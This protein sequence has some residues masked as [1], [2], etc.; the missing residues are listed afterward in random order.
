[1]KLIVFDMDGVLVDSS[2]SHT[3]A[4]HDLWSRYG[5]E[6]PEY[7]AIAGRPTREVVAAYTRDIEEWV[8][9]KQQRARDY[10][11]AEPVTFDDVLPSLETIRQSG[12][13]MAVATGAS[14][15]TAE[16]LLRRAG[17]AGYFEFVLTAEAVQ[18]GKPDPEL[19]RTA[20]E[21][22][23][24]APGDVAVVEDSAAGLEAAVAASTWV[25]C[26]RTGLSIRS[27]YFLGSYR[28]LLEF[29]AAIGVLV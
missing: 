10:L 17:I 2:P 1:M 8:N 23:G 4:F 3:R 20:V 28:G 6:G 19:Y 24:A 13:R 9:F 5:V 12:A 22:F 11:A 16:L 21:R 25:A 18:A 15:T 27:P 29:A 7:S 26:V 14:R